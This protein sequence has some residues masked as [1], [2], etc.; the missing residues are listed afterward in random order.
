MD[1]INSSDNTLFIKADAIIVFNN[2]EL[3]MD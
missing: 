1:M 3:N 2:L